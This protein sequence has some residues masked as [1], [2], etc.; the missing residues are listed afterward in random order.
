MNL[1]FVEDDSKVLMANRQSGGIPE[2]LRKMFE[3]EIKEIESLTGKKAIHIMLNIL[4]ARGEHD[5]TLVPMHTDTVIG[6]PDRYHLPLKTSEHCFFWDEVNGFQF[7]KVGQWYKVDY[8]LRHT[9]G[10]FGTTE[11]THLIVDLI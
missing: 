3:K 11:R 10:N 4:P 7:M 2:H 1:Q 8:R 9:I 6:N 5:L